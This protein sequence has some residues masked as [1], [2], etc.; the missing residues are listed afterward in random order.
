[1]QEIKS[2]DSTCH[3]GSGRHSGSNTHEQFLGGLGAMAFFR[4]ELELVRYPIRSGRTLLQ[5]VLWSWEG[6]LQVC[7]CVLLQTAFSHVFVI[8]DIL[9]LGAFDHSVLYATAQLTEG[10][11]ARDQPKQP[12]AK[13]KDCRSNSGLL[14]NL[15][16]IRE[17]VG[18]GY[19]TFCLCRTSP[20]IEVRTH[21]HPWVSQV[22]TPLL[23]PS[24]T[25]CI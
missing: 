14:H 13:K 10:R 25:R 7:F 11:S 5:H 1:M 9:Q 23:A 18:I 17:A 21:T 15:I 12:P 3:F 20:S 6:T 8:H 16:P 4:K 22:L 24:F 2:Y 19:P